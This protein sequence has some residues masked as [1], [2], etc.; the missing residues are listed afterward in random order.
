MKE[1]LKSH[2]GWVVPS[3]SQAV[4]FFKLIGYNEISERT[5]DPIREINILFISNINQVIELIEPSS[6]KSIVYSYLK[7]NGPGPYHLCLSIDLNKE[8]SS[9]EKIKFFP[10][11]QKQEAVALG[12]TNVQFYYSN[13]IGMIEIASD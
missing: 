13:N 8:I 5:Y 3:I 9:L 12:N 6:N 10:I 4:S 2:I 11:T 7:R 1:E